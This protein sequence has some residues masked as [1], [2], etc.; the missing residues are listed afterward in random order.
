MGQKPRGEKKVKAPIGQTEGVEG[1]GLLEYIRR[2]QGNLD[3]LP[4]WKERQ[5]LG[6]KGVRTKA[7]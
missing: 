7:N 3:C 2:D 5:G 4:I 6:V 1:L